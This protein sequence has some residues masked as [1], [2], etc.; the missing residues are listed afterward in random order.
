ME[1]E[2]ILGRD[3]VAQIIRNRMGRL[4]EQG[5]ELQLN[6]EFIKRELLN[7][8]LTSE[9]NGELSLQLRDITAQIDSLSDTVDWHQQRLERLTT[10]GE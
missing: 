4:A 2:K 8:G 6:A 1:F 5:F 3:R 7:E 9:Q 10:D